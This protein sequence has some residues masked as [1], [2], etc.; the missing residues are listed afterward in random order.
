MVVS[1]GMVSKQNVKAN[2][3]KPGQ[4]CRET[5]ERERAKAGESSRTGTGH[6]QE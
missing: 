5:K 2:E 4:R 3:E 6:G 1:S